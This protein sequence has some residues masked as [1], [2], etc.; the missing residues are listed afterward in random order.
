MHSR[1]PSHFFHFSF[2]DINGARAAL[3][4]GVA[5]GVGV[6]VGVIVGPGRVVTVGSGAGGVEH[7]VKASRQPATTTR[8]K[9]LT[10]RP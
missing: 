7:A 6:R 4:V 3:T 5:V 1:L 8:G 9:R 10:P 2:C